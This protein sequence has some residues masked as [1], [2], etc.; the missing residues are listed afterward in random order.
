[1]LKQHIALHVTSIYTW[2][3]YIRFSWTKAGLGSIK[4]KKPIFC[5]LS[6]VCVHVS[7]VPIPPV[8]WGPVNL[9][10]PHPFYMKSCRVKR[11]SHKHSQY[12]RPLGAGLVACGTVSPQA[13]LSVR[14]TG[15]RPPAPNTLLPKRHHWARRLILANIK[16]PKRRE[17]W[18]WENRSG[19]EGTRR[20]QGI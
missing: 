4:E 3:T 2:C 15:F 13:V 16:L 1:M 18:P 11:Q 8:L 14:N 20:G 5:Q 17:F 10:R 12:G 19:P 7:I 6:S 9:N